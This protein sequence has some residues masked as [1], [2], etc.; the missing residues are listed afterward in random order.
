[1]SF[2]PKSAYF[3]RE[4]SMKKTATNGTGIFTENRNGV[5]LYHLQNTD[6]AFAFS[7]E[8]AWHG[9]GIKFTQF[10]RSGITVKSMPRKKL[11]FSRAEKF[12]PE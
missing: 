2:I 5:E 10:G 7:R 4:L 11:P 9:T 12:S 8:E 1:M 6:K 3:H